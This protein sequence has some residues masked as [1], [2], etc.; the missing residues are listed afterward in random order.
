MLRGFDV[1]GMGNIQIDLLYFI[2]NGLQNS[3]LDA[4]VPIIYSFTDVRVMLSLILLALFFSWMLKKDKIN[5]IAILCLFA[6]CLTIAFTMV[7]K[8]FYP[9]TR[10]FIALEG[11]RL[12]VHDN[13]FYS[14]PSGHFAISSAIVSVILMKAENHKHELSLLSILYLLIL[15][16]VVIYG[17]VHYPID[18]IGGGI[19]GV[20]AAVIVV[21]YQKAFMDC[22]KRLF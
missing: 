5:E 19:I 2:N 13:G 10:P 15:A 18:V 21:R 22:I 6:Y 4:V 1:V 17:G 11:V 12:V 3:I 16:F 7:S 8:T 14:F 20:V 9:S